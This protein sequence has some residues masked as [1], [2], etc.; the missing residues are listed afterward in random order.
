MRLTMKQMSGSSGIVQSMTTPSGDT[1]YGGYKNA[2][3]T[4]EREV[5]ENMVEITQWTIDGYKKNVK[6]RRDSVARLESLRN[7][8]ATLYGREAQHSA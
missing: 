6:G 2:W 1:L 3:F 8:M 7:I 5:L 4:T